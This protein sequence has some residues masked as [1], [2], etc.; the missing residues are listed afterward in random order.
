[1]SE[2]LRFLDH[3]SQNY[4]LFGPRG[5]GKSTWLQRRYPEA[6]RLDLLDTALQRQYLA[7]PERLKDFL[8]AHK[9]HMTIIIDEIQRVPQML[10]IVH[11]QIENNKALHFILTGSSARKLKQEGVDLLAGRAVVR[12][13]HPFMA[14]EMGDLFDLEKSLE[15]GMVPL[16]RM[17]EFP[18]KTLRGYI[19][20]YLEQEVK[21]E[22]I[23]RRLDI[24]NRFLEA[25][26]FSQAQVLNTAAIARDC[27]VSRNTVESYIAILEDLLLAVRIPVF[28]K[29]AKRALVSHKKFFFF[30]CG[31][32]QS[33]RPAG[34]I[35]HPSEIAG[36]ALEGLVMQ[37]LRAWIDYRDC[38]LQMYY[39]RTLA[40]SEV[41]F[42]LYGNDGFY[43]LEV[44]NSKT[45]RPED[46]RGLKSF[47]QEYPE[48]S[49]YFLYRGEEKTD[50]DGI[51]CMPVADFLKRLDPK[52][53][54][55]M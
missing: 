7:Y 44:K 26:T 33:L 36:P 22:G 15:K 27:A 21:A 12:H 11:Q 20:L 48:C 14:A 46:L 50:R 5:T 41:D 4:F 43:A 6:A 30:D 1:M 17:A 19:D 51:H 23:V 54:L 55:P 52:N 10:S 35:D 38:R 25:L 45:I 29:R 53:P 28:S 3:F 13:M 32:Y 42:I 47:R 18:E 24:F 39:W 34:P 31:V 9:N 2:L 40:G 8:A 16:V 49:A 37:H